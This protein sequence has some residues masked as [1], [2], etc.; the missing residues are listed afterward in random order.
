MPFVL[1]L[2]PFLLRIL[3]KKHYFSNLCTL[4][5]P[6][7]I[8]ILY[9]DSFCLVVNKPSDLLVHHSRFAGTVPE[10]SLVNLLRQQTGL[11]ELSPA[12]RLDRKTSGIVLFVKQKEYVSRFQEALQNEASEKTYWALQRGFLPDEGRID[13]P[14]K[15]ERGNYK[16]ALTIYRTLHQFT[17]DYDI[18]PYPQQRYSLVALTPKT[19]RYHQLR[20]HANKIAHPIINDPKHGN[21]HHNHFFEENLG[22]HQ[23]FLHAISLKFR[24]PIFDSVHAISV[25]PPAFWSKF[26]TPEEWGEI[27]TII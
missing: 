16:E 6:V 18:P 14:V 3:H 9:E 20:I 5:F 15:N 23:L 4:N 12:H 7:K 11:N 1:Q 17:R 22:I 26:F 19:G 25:E 8:E 13:S 24:H 21:R 2:F 27:K 10:D